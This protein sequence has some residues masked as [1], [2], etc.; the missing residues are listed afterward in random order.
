[1]KDDRKLTYNFTEHGLHYENGLTF[2]A[3]K[4]V[5]LTIGTLQINVDYFTG[6]IL[7]VIGF[8]PLV[9]AT[10]MRIDIPKLVEESFFLPMKGIE[11]LK[12]VAYDYFNFFPMCEDYFVY[13]KLP[14]VAYDEEN[15]RILLGTRDATYDKFVLINKNIICGIDRK[16]NLKSLL[17]LLD[18]IKR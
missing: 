13:E 11:Y 15:R 16:N 6:N 14:I 8:L 12:G 2:E 3:D 9:K 17:I 7:S 10:K 18:I 1:M 5:T 4:I